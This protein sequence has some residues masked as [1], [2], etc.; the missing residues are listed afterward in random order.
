MEGCADI[1]YD[2]GLILLYNLRVVKLAAIQ[3][4]PIS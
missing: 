3:S 1:T 4:F 2:C